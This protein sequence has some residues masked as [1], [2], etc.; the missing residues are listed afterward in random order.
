MKRQ[1]QVSPV[2]IACA[3]QAAP[4]GGVFFSDLGRVGLNQSGDVVFAFALDP[5]T[6]PIGLNSGV[7]RFP[8][9][10]QTL[11]ALLKPDDTAPGGG[12][13]KGTFFNTSV[14]N[15]GVSVFSGI[16]TGADIAPGPSGSSSGDSGF[17]G[18][19]YA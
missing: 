14:N 8:H 7:Y 2:A 10:I 3:G 15:D 19:N 11:T 18:L 9:S 13:F 16:V 4:G 17:T 6:F 12:T 1:G 5:F